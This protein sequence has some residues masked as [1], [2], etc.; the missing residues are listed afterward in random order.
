MAMPGLS[1]RGFLGGAAGLAAVAALPPAGRAAAAAKPAVTP[2]AGGTVDLSAYHASNY[3]KTA[4][5][6][7]GYIGMPLA[8]TLQKVLITTTS[9]PASPG[10]KLTQLSAVGCQFLISVQPSTVLSSSER[11]A[12]VNYLTM[13]TNAGISYRAILFSEANDTA[14]TNQQAWQAY[15][16][17]YA[18]AIQ[19]AGV[20]CAYCPG[21]NSQSIARAEAFFPSNPTPDELWIDFYA[22]GFRG[23][24]RIDQLVAQAKAAGISAGL[25]EWGWHAGRSL[26]NPM[27][28]PWW[29]FYCNYLAHLGAIGNLQ[30]GAVYFSQSAAPVPLNVI[31]SPNDPRIPGIRK[32]S[33]AVQTVP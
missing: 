31:G 18:P 33:Q 14:F 11:S 32:V 3:V 24:V 4:D 25:A 2:L 27:T 22:T 6:M 12:M 26:L 5:I 19:A 8:R 7:D 9:F 23:A 21:C 29:T 13:L 28:I 17:Y 15:W 20:S 16:S 10:P 30:L 1:R